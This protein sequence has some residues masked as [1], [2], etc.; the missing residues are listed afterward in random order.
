MDGPP[1]SYADYIGIDVAKATFDVAA[2]HRGLRLSLSYDD[3]GLRRLVEQLR[4][5]GACFIVLE[6]TGG[7]ERRL[8]AELSDAGFTVAVVNP[9]QVR[10]FARA[11]GRLAKTDRLDATVLADF[12]ERIRPRPL[13]PPAEHEWELKALVNR[14]RQLVE[15]RTMETN[16]LDAATAPLAR[17]SIRKVLDLLRRQVDQLDAA[18]AALVQSD[19]DW[20]QKNEVLRSVPGV[21][22]V[23]STALLADLPELGRLNRQEVAALAGLAP[24]NRDSGQHAG[25]RAIWGGRVSVRSV[26]YMAALTARR[27]NPLIARFAQRLEAAGK[28]FKVVLTACMRKLLIVLNLLVKNYARWDPKLAH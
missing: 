19:D 1:T 7:L 16:R 26:L 3:A 10:D 25:R 24:F 12:A 18:I 15:L 4:P 22:P 8:A 28:P 11:T 14:R 20:R 17:K 13:T 27:C 6:A 2:R 5:L 23:T 9:R 21:G